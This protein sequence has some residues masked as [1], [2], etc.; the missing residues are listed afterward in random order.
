MSTARVAQLLEQI[1]QLSD[2]EQLEFEDALEQ[3]RLASM[4]VAAGLRTAEAHRE[5]VAT[6]GRLQTA[7]RAR[8]IAGLTLEPSG[9]ELAERGLLGP[10]ES[11]RYVAIGRLV[12]DPTTTEAPGFFLQRC[13][14][15]LEYLIDDVEAGAYV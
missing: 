7:I 9:T 10:E 14:K 15:E 11:K 6:W 4:R 1:D 13:T 8:Q 3:R 12:R 5:L 2:A